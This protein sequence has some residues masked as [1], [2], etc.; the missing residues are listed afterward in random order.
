MS[1]FLK[2]LL[3]L[4]Y[5]KKL[6]LISQFDKK[7]VA[8]LDKKVN[9]L[10]SLNP[11]ASFFPDGAEPYKGFS[12]L[13]APGFIQFEYEGTYSEGQ[14]IFLWSNHQLKFSRFAQ[15]YVVSMEST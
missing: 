10:I 4:T 12:I 15:A 5:D 11:T 14:E 1:R 13:Y 8:T 7:N 9:T 3:Y 2:L 6:N